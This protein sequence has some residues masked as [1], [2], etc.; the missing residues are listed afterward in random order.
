ME[1]NKTVESSKG[2]WVC[3]VQNELDDY[4]RGFQAESLEEIF[5]FITI[6]ANEG[7]VQVEIFPGEDAA[8]IRLAEV[9][10]FLRAAAGLSNP[11]AQVQE[12]LDRLMMSATM[13]EFCHKMQ[14]LAETL[15]SIEAHRVPATEIAG[16]GQ[17]AA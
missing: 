1:E 7:A 5:K 15:S 13:T 2:G 6:K 12:D 17:E 4:Q 11:E 16:A 14:S 3:I 10:A 8:R 9:T